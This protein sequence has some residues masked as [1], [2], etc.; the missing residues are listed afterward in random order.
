[1]LVGAHFG[2]PG[3]QLGE[4]GLIVGIHGPASG[5]GLA[6]RGFTTGRRAVFLAAD[7]MGQAADGVLLAI[8]PGLVHKLPAAH[9]FA[10][11]H[12]RLA[13]GLIPRLQ[14]LEH[15]RVRAVQA[16]GVFL[17]AP[18]GLKHHSRAKTAAV[19]GFCFLTQ[20]PHGRRG[21]FKPK[22]A[23]SYG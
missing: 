3:L 21:P 6:A 1:M 22:Q 18:P 9:G 10:L 20:R 15:P 2:V 5:V 4:Q 12:G 19:P 23:A 16:G 8:W 11:G 14:R 7:H 13:G 17:A